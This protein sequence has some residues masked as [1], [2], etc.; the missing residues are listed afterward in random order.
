RATEL[1]GRTEPER[2]LDTVDR[3]HMIQWLDQQQQSRDYWRRRN[4]ALY[5][6]LEAWQR[7]S[8]ADD[9]TGFLASRFGTMHSGLVEYLKTD[10]P[11]GALVE[12]NRIKPGET[13]GEDGDLF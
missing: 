5:A 10:D 4:R 11:L 12:A 7:Y 2:R 9:K 1:A 3:L 13:G 6:D 8:A